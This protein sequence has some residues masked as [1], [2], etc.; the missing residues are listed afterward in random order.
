MRVDEFDFEL[1]AAQIAQEARPRGTSRLLVVDRSAGAWQERA[2]SELPSLLS[3]GDLM[4]ANDTRVFPARLVGRRD[5]SGG[6]VE[7]FLLEREATPEL[8]GD[9]WAALVHPGQKLKAGTRAVFED[10][11]RAPG[12]RIEA[13]ILARK[14]FGRR[15]VRLT[16][17]GAAS[18]DAAVDAIGHVPL[19]PYIDRPDRAEDRERYQ[20]VFAESRGSVAA[21]TAGLHFDAATIAGIRDR[22]V[23]WRTITLHVGYGTFKPVRVDRVEEHTVDPERYTISSATA[24]AIRATR[25]RGSRVIAV[26]SGRRSPT[27]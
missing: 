2:F 7:C 26:I 10:P 4:V 17:S 21:P 1:P 24:D 16:A 25:S 14:F 12:V 11:D 18:V 13:E 3:A 15:L 27:R 8:S 9:V 23:D 6:R 22:G 20:T 5:P 19:P